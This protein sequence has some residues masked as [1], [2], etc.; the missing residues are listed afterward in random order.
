MSKALRLGILRGTQHKPA[1]SCAAGT[2]WSNFLNSQALLKTIG[3]NAIFFTDS[4]EFSKPEC[5]EWDVRPM[6]ELPNASDIDCLYSPNDLMLHHC[7]GFRPAHHPPVTVEIGTSHFTDQWNHCFIGMAQQTIQDFDGFIFKSERTRQ[8]FFT[9]FAEWGSLIN[10]ALPKPFSI[11]LPNHLDPRSEDVDPTRRITTRRALGIPSDIILFLGFSRIQDVTKAD[12]LALLQDLSHLP[13]G[14]RK[15]LGFILAGG[16]PRYTRNDRYVENLKFTASA[17]ELGGGIHFLNERTPWSRLDLMSAADVFVHM[18]VGVQETTPRVLLEAMA[19]RLPIIAT[20][21]AGMGEVVINQ[22]G[23]F[24]IPVT[25]AHP[26]TWINDSFG[27]LHPMDFNYHLERSVAYDRHTFL[28]SI[29]LL[30]TNF[31]LRQRFG[32]F[33]RQQIDGPLSQAVGINS[34][35]KFMEE[36]AKARQQMTPRQTRLLVDGRKLLHGLAGELR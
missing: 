15:K 33:N 1:L 16:Q 21:W 23:G 22:K 27:C 32:E 25:I 24:L 14:L 34:R 30:S 17:I 29:D 12:F 19:H 10:S 28:S 5:S 8:M 9:T 7:F 11:V 3:T 6:N 13:A 18:S 4:F 2:D 20:D 36:L 26:P 35:L 31:N